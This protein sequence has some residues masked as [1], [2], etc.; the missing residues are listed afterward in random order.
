MPAS[1]GTLQD[2]ETS[3]EFVGLMPS[4]LTNKRLLFWNSIDRLILSVNI[5]NLPFIQVHYKLAGIVVNTLTLLCRLS[6]V[7]EMAPVK[8]ERSPP[9]QLDHPQNPVT[10][11]GTRSLTTSWPT[12]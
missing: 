12:K 8:L 2:Q 6:E 3:R 10:F 1:D 4:G 9:L 5:R 11:C 7:I